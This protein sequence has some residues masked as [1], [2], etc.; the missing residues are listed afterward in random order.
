MAIQN[1]SQKELKIVAG[2]LQPKK[3]TL[4]TIL[5]KVLNTK[6][7][8][9]HHAVPGHVPVSMGISGS[10]HSKASS[11]SASSSHSPSSSSSSSGSKS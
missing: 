4:T 10:V 9:G 11:H 2:G 1:L 5:G 8:A 3:P 7:L 6:M